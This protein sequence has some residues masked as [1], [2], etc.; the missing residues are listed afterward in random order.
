MAATASTIDDADADRIVE[1]NARHGLDTDS[2]TAI[3]MW[4]GA[5]LDLGGPSRRCGTRTIGRLIRQH[6]QLDTPI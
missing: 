4:G 2:D 5:G 1:L 6:E 3:P